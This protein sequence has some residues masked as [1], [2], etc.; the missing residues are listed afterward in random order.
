MFRHAILLCAAALRAA[1]ADDFDS[2]LSRRLLAD[3]Q[4][5]IEAQIH[6][7]TRVR[8]M[9]P[10]STNAAW[11]A[12]AAAL[13]EQLLTQVYL[14][15]EAAKWRRIPTRPEWLDVLPGDGY[16]VRKFRYE[17]LPGMWIPGLLYEPDKLEGRVPVVVNLNGHEGAGVSIDYIQQRCMHLARNGVLAYNYE[18][19]VK[20]QL[21]DPNFDHARLNQ[22]DLT[23]TSGLAPFFLAH[24]RLLDI[25]LQH[26]N[27][28]PE[29]VA[30]TGL[31]GGGWQTITL[32][33][34]DTRVKLAV[35]VAGY[36]SF[37][38][39]AQFDKDLGD[40]EQTP[41]DLA[42]YADYT[43]LTAML[44]PRP[45]LLINNAYDNCCFRADYAMGPLVA[46]A[47]P[48]FALYGRTDRLRHYANF[49]PGHNY[50]LDNRQALYR[51]LN[52]HFLAKGRRISLE[53]DAGQKL[54]TADQLKM[55]LPEPNLTFNGLAK[56]LASGLPRPS[57]E[58]ADVQRKRLK[59]IVRWPEYKVDA[60]PAGSAGAGGLQVN[61]WRLMMGDGW[62]V[63]AV[64]FVPEGAQ[65]ATVLMGDKG[66]GE[67]GAAVRTLVGRR[68]RV[69]AIDPFY[70]GESAIETK[71]YLYALL[72][73]S[74]GERPLGVQAAEIAAAARWMKT[75]AGSVAIEAHGPRM[76]LAGLVAA[77]ADP[78]AASTVRLFQPMKSVR[79]PI[80]SSMKFSDAPELFCFGLLEWFDMPQLTELA[81]PARVEADPR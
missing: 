10:V 76:S 68:Q 31:S 79:E 16:R 4:P 67:L 28:D 51:F 14:R 48:F 2:H 22:I 49:D 34:L 54:R 19:F 23:G 33:A 15:G 55:P 73:S 20:G 47:R 61:S 32:S 39:R 40:S 46:Y 45:S 7:A 50:G 21:N 52:E 36:S 11:D 66:R 30:V 53:E 63:P 60:R 12:Q 77:A 42:R 25:A 13:R 3:R 56:R 37:I 58:P 8:P 72:L 59:E 18:W 65:G 35:P 41:V 29:R 78:Q 80:D 5:L 43:H 44:A 62:T 9:P 27:A 57:Q 26:K 81:R 17:V 74:V 75:R 64:E 71:S 38:T 1:A 6:L 69:L 24:R 70:T